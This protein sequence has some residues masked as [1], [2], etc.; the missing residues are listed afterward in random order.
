MKKFSEKNSKESFRD[1]PKVVAFIPA[2]GGSKSIPRKNIRP[3]CGEPLI[4]WT[5]KAANECEFID[6]VY[7]STDD[8]MIRSTVEQFGMEKVTVISRSPETATDFASTE[9]AMLE[10]ASGYD[11]DVIVLIQATSPLLTSADL[12]GGL[13]QYFSSG[14]DSIVSVTRQK[15]FIWKYEGDAAVPVN[16][17]YFKRPRR[18]EWEGFLVENGAFYVTSRERLLQSGS[19]ISG[20]VQL[21]EMPDFTYHELDEQADWIV[22]E[23]IKRN[24]MLGE[25]ESGLNR[26]LFSRIRLLICDV[27]GVLTDA[28]MYYSDHGDELKKF[29]TRDGKGIELVRQAGIHVMFLT[30]ENIELVRR[31]AEKLG[32]EHLFMGIKNKKAFLEQFFAD[33]P[34]YD[35]STTAYIGD[36]INDLECIQSAALSAVPADGHERVLSAAAYV[37]RRNGGHGCVREFCDLILSGRII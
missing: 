36:D 3:F 15:R 25:R 31:R 18:Q 21:Y 12:T 2:R 20:T 5:A 35:F 16:Y 29:N 7:V 13:A 32:I 33:H 28:G 14:A 4:Y 11:F 8:D 24:H 22:L 6:E 23:Q 19:R 1:H 10:F 27:D 17:D 26:D 37:C 34:F 9:S 30:S